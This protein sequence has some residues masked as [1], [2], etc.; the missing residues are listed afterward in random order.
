[1][2]KITVVL[3]DIGSPITGESGFFDPP[4]DQFLTMGTECYHEDK[5]EEHGI[6]FWMQ[7]WK[8]GNR[9]YSRTKKSQV[10]IPWTSCLYVEKLPLDN[11]RNKYYS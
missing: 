1:M 4:S 7:T 3:T 11:S 10:F 9:K 2:A 6:G 5:L 8:P